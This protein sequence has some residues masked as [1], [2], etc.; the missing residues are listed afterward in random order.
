MIE[1]LKTF[2]ALASTIIFVV[3]LGIDT[4]QALNRT[5]QSPIQPFSRVADS[6]PQKKL[7]LP[8]LHLVYDIYEL[9]ISPP[10]TLTVKM[11]LDVWARTN[12]EGLFTSLD[13]TA[14]L[15]GSGIKG[16]EEIHTVL[17]GHS[18]SR[19][20]SQTNRVSITTDIPSNAPEIRALGLITNWEKL[21]NEARHANNNGVSL[22]GTETL[23]SVPVDVIVQ[24]QA[25]SIRTRGIDT[26]Y[27]NVHSHA[28]VAQ[29]STTYDLSG[30]LLSA[31]T[32]TVHKYETVSSV[33][34]PVHLFTFKSPSGATVEK[35]RYPKGP[36]FGQP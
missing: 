31:V 20:D 9:D 24:N 25:T 30:A 18:L 5:A 3:I 11:S 10:L 7:I 33:A 32:V 12:A 2:A 16:T 19:Y 17:S 23:G 29:D 8:V 28:L 26:I 22:L 14:Y 35:Y 34:A 13:R 4:P 27:L 36:S 1:R 6:K 15:S 21:L